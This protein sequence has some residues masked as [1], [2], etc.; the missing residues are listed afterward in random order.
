[1]ATPLIL[2]DSPSVMN[3]IVGNFQ[4]QPEGLYIVRTSNLTEHPK[5]V[6]NP[7]DIGTDVV[8]TGYV[9]DPARRSGQGEA[10]RLRVVVDLE[11]ALP[12]E[13]TR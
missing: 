9:I 7:D 3:Q 1:M 8:V 10:L 6:V 2:F 11:F 12:G 13:H 5:P 4:D